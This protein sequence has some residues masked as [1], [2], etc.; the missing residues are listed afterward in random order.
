MMHQWLNR[1][2]QKNGKT[3]C[4]TNEM[5]GTSIRENRQDTMENHFTIKNTSDDDACCLQQQFTIHFKICKNKR[6]TSVTRDTLNIRQAVKIITVRN[7]TTDG[8]VRV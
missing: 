3:K 2:T 7:A 1:K 5:A 8:I 4:E 6:L